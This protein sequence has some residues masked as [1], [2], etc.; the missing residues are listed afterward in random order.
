[1]WIEVRVAMVG[2]PSMPAICVFTES[3]DSISALR[4]V[5]ECAVTV[6][7]MVRVPRSMSGEAG[8]VSQVWCVVIGCGC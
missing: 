4:V 1:M 7:S 5:G 6:R 2:S 3:I 8:I